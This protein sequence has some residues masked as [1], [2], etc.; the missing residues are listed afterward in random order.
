MR[1]GAV[2]TSASVSVHGPVCVRVYA[3][4]CGTVQSKLVPDLHVGTSPAETAWGE[5]S[6]HPNPSGGHCYGLS[7]SPR[8]SWGAQ[9]AKQVE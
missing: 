7:C 4:E 5:S 6:C 8:N 3:R 2:H 9:L 1:R